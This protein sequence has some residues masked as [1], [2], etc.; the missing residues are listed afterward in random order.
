[1][2]P[3]DCLLIEKKPSI[4]A[5]VAYLQKEYLAQSGSSMVLLQRLSQNCQCPQAFAQASTK[6]VFSPAW[7]IFSFF[8]LANLTQ[9]NMQ[10]MDLPQVKRMK[11]VCLRV[12]ATRRQN[13][14]ASFTFYNVLS[15]PVCTILIGQ[16][17]SNLCPAKAALFD[18]TATP[19]PYQLQVVSHWH[20]YQRPQTSGRLYFDSEADRRKVEKNSHFNM[21]PFILPI[22]ASRTWTSVV[23][24]TERSSLSICHGHAKCSLSSQEVA[25]AKWIVV[26]TTKMRKQLLQLLIYRGNTGLPTH[27]SQSTG[28][29]L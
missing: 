15:T 5:Y 23:F 12:K 28:C 8:S 29:V 4:E 24:Y 27:S 2:I 7:K 26:P 11:N 10:C 3:V 21:D 19:S 20:C 18:F 14:C 1:M 17:L 25:L 13:H 9:S 6:M 16:L 22:L